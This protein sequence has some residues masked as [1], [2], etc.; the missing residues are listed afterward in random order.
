[1]RPATA[2]IALTAFSL[3]FGQ[4]VLSETPLE[5]HVLWTIAHEGCNAYSGDEMKAIRLL[6][7]CFIEKETEAHN[8][9]ATRL[10]IKASDSD[11]LEATRAAL[12]LAYVRYQISENFEWVLS[13]ESQ[14]NLF[15]EL[16]QSKN[17]QKIRMIYHRLQGHN[18]NARNILSAVSDEGIQQMLDRPR[19]TGTVS[20]GISYESLKNLDSLTVPRTVTTTSTVSLQT[21]MM[22]TYGFANA[23]L[24]K[25]ILE[26]NQILSHFLVPPGVDPATIPIPA[27][28]AVV[29]PSIP[30]IGRVGSIPLKPYSGTSCSTCDVLNLEAVRALADLKTKGDNQIEPEVF[31]HIE[32]P[33]GQLESV[34]QPSQAVYGW[35]IKFLGLNSIESR[36]LNLISKVPVGV[37]DSGVDLAHKDLKN[38]F[39]STP[40]AIADKQWRAGAIGYNFLN[41]GTEPW[42]ELGD[43]HG[44]HVSG[45]V[46][47]D[48][49]SKWKPALAQALAPNIQLV[50]LK[51]VGTVNK[52]DSA[53]AEN[54]IRDAFDKG[55]RIFNLSFEFAAYSES[56]QL[57]LKEKAHQT[58]TL[59]VIAAGNNG[60]I[61]TGEDL[62]NNPDRQMS[63]RGDDSSPLSEVIFVAALDE[64]GKL[65]SFS[66]YGKAAVEIAAPGSN[67]SSTIRNGGYGLLCGTSQAAPFVT[68][69][70]AILLAEIPS[71]SL[72]EVHQRIVDT[73]DWM[74]ELKPFVRDGCRLN[75]QKAVI[76]NS[77]LIELKSG[78]ILKGTV[79]SA[80]IPLPQPSTAP[81]DPKYERV[82]FD[83]SGEITIVTKSGRFKRSGL[84]AASITIDLENAQDCPVPANSNSC[85]LPP[86]TIRDIV[87]RVS[88]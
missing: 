29:L 9:Q 7:Q 2:F 38:S 6:R 18:P 12:S 63:F 41:R 23:G 61:S 73:C 85:S 83:D 80:Q 79:S 46:I 53:T 70:A 3:P 13:H 77:D 15:R 60:A 66:N 74:P 62:D 44:T 50:E 17:Y 54:A 51:I 71:L 21:L 16:G 8:P 10:L 26:K 30:R 34:T 40:P 55:I 57:Y 20:S 43:S 47:G 48:Q 37:V 78:P 19:L 72:P 75:I 35:Y 84:T 58:S 4:L 69:T 76:A 24:T 28:T 25:L 88:N 42:D 32:F 14:L 59:F 82:W 1:M 64:R 22:D 67:I 39:W 52:F 81:A 87:F 36:D 56:M 65:A 86:S 31:G 49:I 45:L 33:V 5:S 27:Q 11:L 68:L